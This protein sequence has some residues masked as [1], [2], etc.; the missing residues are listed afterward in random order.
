MSNY[1]NTQSVFDS[2]GGG[3]TRTGL[4]TQIIVMVN[5][6][7]VGAIQSFGQTQQRSTRPITEVG[8][9]GVIEIVPSSATQ[10]SLSIQ[11]IMFDGL[12][13]PEAFSRG[14]VNIAA[15]RIPFDIVVIDRS[16][17]DPSNAIGTDNE[18]VTVYKNCWF[19]NLSK[20]FSSQDYIVS[21]T[22]SVQCETVYSMKAIDSSPV[23]DTQELRGLT[24]AEDE[25]GIE[26]LVDSGAIVSSQRGAMGAAGIYEAGTQGAA[27]VTPNP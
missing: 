25:Y 23:A 24:A 17:T 2:S 19:T 22:A 1:S 8:T 3:S 16:A 5:G 4:S 26:Q 11:R 6:N 15:Q 27:Q 20:T 9:D 10:I 21:E 7:P 14:F 12:S 13:L 18:R